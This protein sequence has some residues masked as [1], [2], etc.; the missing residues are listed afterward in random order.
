MVD[1]PVVVATPGRIPPSLRPRRPPCLVAGHVVGPAGHAAVVATGGRARVVWTLGGGGRVLGRHGR[2]RGAGDGRV[3]IV[4]VATA[5]DQRAAVNR[6]ATGRTRMNR[7][8]ERS[9]GGWGDADRRQTYPPGH[10]RHI[11]SA[12]RSDARDA[13]GGVPWPVLESYS[14]QA[15]RRSS[16]ARPRPGSWDTAG[17]GRSTCCSG[18]SPKGTP[19]RADAATTERPRRRPAQG[20]RGDRRRCR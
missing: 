17:S 2:D 6:A 11:G 7:C 15:R 9:F 8:T 18:C 3:V 10:D 14:V 13:G 12:Q 19:D 5:G 4:V 16:L 1:Q 20:G